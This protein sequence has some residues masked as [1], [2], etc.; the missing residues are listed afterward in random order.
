MPTMSLVVYQG[1]QIGKADSSGV[2]SPVV[3]ADSQ[4][5]DCVDVWIVEAAAR[6]V[7]GTFIFPSASNGTMEGMNLQDTV[8]Q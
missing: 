6:T 5:I 4:S 1:A 2:S 3:M 7:Q 8:C